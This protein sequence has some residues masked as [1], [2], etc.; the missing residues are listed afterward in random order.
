MTELR[1]LERKHML[2]P[3]NATLRNSLLFVRADL[4]ANLHDEKSFALFQLRKKYFESE[5]KAG[6]MIAL[7]D[8]VNRKQI[9]YSCNI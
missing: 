9:F 5:D 1:I 6:K 8:Y 3:K 4:K 7:L 2:D